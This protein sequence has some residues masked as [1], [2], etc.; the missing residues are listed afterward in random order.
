MIIRKILINTSIIIKFIPKISIHHHLISILHKFK[1]FISIKIIARINYKGLDHKLLK[2]YI[3]FTGLEIHTSILTTMIIPAATIAAVV[4]AI[5]FLVIVAIKSSLALV[6]VMH[7]PVVM[8]AMDFNVNAYNA[9][10]AA[11]YLIALLIRMDA[12]LECLVVVMVVLHVAI[13]VMDNV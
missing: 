5:A 12:V 6:V 11:E 8:D 2:N 10:L 9:C 1:S 4:M 3:R 13:I 7:C